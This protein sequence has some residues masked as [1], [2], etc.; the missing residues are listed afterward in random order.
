MTNEEEK[1]VNVGLW[2]VFVLSGIFFGMLV[3]SATY[4]L[5]SDSWKREAVEN[6]HAE[7]FIKDHVQNWRWKEKP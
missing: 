2:T 5:T 3:W 6:G 4:F 7:W 1:G